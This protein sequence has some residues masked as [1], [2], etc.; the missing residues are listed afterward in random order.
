MGCTASKAGVE[1][2]AVVSVSCP[3]RP[4]PRCWQR[5]G[6]LVSPPTAVN[7]LPPTMQAAVSPHYAKAGSENGSDMKSKLCGGKPE[8]LPD[9]ALPFS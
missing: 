9:S 1:A 8:S 5:C 6:L 4:R 7:H 3:A 2:E